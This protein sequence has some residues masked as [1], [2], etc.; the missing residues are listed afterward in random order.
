MVILFELSI[1]LISLVF[2]PYSK[3]SLFPKNYVLS[4]WVGLFFGSA[5]FFLTYLLV[6]KLNQK[7]VK[8]YL[9]DFHYSYLGKNK[10][11]KLVYSPLIIAIS[12]EMFFRGL[13]YSFF[14]FWISQLLFCLIHT[15]KFRERTIVVISIFFYGLAFSVARY[16][17]G[18]L[19][20]PIIAHALFTTLRIYYFP[21]YIKR[22]PRA[23]NFCKN[24]K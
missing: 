7:Q 10:W 23:F 14:G 12:E 13:L 20:A 11:V 9:Y 19:L 15:L 21:I 6:R 17:T 3:V 1:F 24:Q 18:S 8:N 4:F 2:W 16:L 5:I 22:H